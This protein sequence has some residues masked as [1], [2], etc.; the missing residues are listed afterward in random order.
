MIDLLTCGQLEPSYMVSDRMLSSFNQDWCFGQL[1]AGAILYGEWSNVELLR[2]RSVFWPIVS[3]SHLIWWVTECCTLSSMIDLLTC[4]QVESSYMVSDR[5]LSSF[6]KIGVLANCQLEPSY[7]VSNWMLYSF[8]HDWS[9]DLWSGGVIL[10][11]EWSNVE[12]LRP[13]SVFWPIVS[14]SHLIWWVTEC[15]TLSS[16]ID[17]LTCGQV[18]SSYMVSNWTLYSF[19]HDWSVDQWAVGAIS[20]VERMNVLLLH[21]WLVCWSVVR[22][23]HLISWVT[24]RCVTSPWFIVNLW[25]VGAILYG[26]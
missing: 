23:R 6:E 9:T 13:R 11:G 8:I 5:M 24:E 12:L 15:C 7:M 16:M 3:W 14:W 25:S 26:E 21:P 2:P 4:G 18:E 19:I 1:S 22:W 20:H 10:Y 17:L